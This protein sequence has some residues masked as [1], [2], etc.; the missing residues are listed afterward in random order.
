MAT[1]VAKFIVVDTWAK[2]NTILG[3]PTLWEMQAIIT[4]FYLTMKFPTPR[5]WGMLTVSKEMQENGMCAPSRRVKRRIHVIWSNQ[6]KGSYKANFQRW[7]RYRRPGPHRPRRVY[8]GETKGRYN[9]SPN[10][11]T[12]CWKSWRSGPNW[13][14]H[15]R[16]LWLTSWK[17]TSMASLGN[18]RR[19]WESPPSSYTT[20]Q[21]S[22]LTIS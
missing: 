17:L 1:S 13:M 21:T 2:H 7:W 11:L 3:T 10:M 5:E 9:R 22:T 18:T 19:R 12:I 8:C 14:M 4:L 20:T 16:K 15:R 6:M